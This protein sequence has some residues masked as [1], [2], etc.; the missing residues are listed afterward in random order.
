MG[1]KPFII[2]GNGNFTVVKAA[3]NDR[4][5]TQFKEILELTDNQ[6]MNVQRSNMVNEYK[7]TAQT[8]K[9][10]TKLKTSIANLVGEVAENIRKA[11]SEY[12]PSHK[13]DGETSEKDSE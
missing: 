3:N 8:R 13:D 6:D 11:D 9:I 5:P 12:E 10:R 1:G 2:E 7:V 4:L